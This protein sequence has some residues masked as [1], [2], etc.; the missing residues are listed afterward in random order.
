MPWYCDTIHGTRALQS[1]CSKGTS[2]IFSIKDRKYACFCEFCIGT[3]VNGLDQCEKHRYLKQWKYAPLTPKC[4][5]P[6]ST[7][8]EMH[9][10]EV[11]VSLD[12]NQVF[13]VVR[14]CMWGLSLIVSF[15]NSNGYC[16][17]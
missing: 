2:D 8:Q 7:W 16:F 1:M 13:D 10:E 9:T 15:K 6:I 14:E 4:P 12:C 5:Y 11:V 3:D 17:N